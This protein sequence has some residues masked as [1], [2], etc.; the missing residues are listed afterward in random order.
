MKMGEQMGEN[1]SF[2][3]LNGKYSCGLQGIIQVTPAHQSPPGAT[4]IAECGPL[5]FHANKS[6]QRTK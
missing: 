6:L 5:F 3:F 2:E 4:F 1:F